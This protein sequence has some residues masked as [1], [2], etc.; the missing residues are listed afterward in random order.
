METLVVT[1]TGKER[2]ILNFPPPH[3]F[4]QGSSWTNLKWSRTRSKLGPTDQAWNSLL[5][6]IWSTTPWPLP[7]TRFPSH[8]PHPLDPRPLR[9]I[10]LVSCHQILRG[11]QVR[12]D[13]PNAPLSSLGAPWER[14]RTVA[15]QTHLTSF[16]DCGCCPFYGT[17]QSFDI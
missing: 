14:A 2:P 7:P 17:Q 11:L 4:T 6:R 9:A 8:L 15:S 1:D 13:D 5:F 3:W 12:G 16:D 10:L